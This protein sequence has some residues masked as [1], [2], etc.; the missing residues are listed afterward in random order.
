VSEFLL[1]RGYEVYPQ[2]LE[3]A[4]HYVSVVDYPKHGYNI[5][6]GYLRQVMRRLDVEIG[7]ETLEELAKLH[8]KCDTYSLFPDAA[9]AVKKAKRLG[10][11]TAIVTTIARF[12][13]QP[14]MASMQ[15]YFD[16]IVTGY[17]VGCEKSNPK[18]R[19]KALNSLGVQAKEAVMIGDEPLVD[20]RI[21]KKLGMHTIFLDRE[22][23]I[24]KK[25][26]EAD[27]EAST[28]TEAITL[29]GKLQTPARDLSLT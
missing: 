14:A 12:V 13:F 18:M 16:T 27:A 9:P 2:S 1:E 7:A 3:A 4:R 19:E 6:Q 20:I 15:Q 11:R 22:G 29:I 28:L 25:P 26:S 21:P 8:K 17:E 10:L 24:R 5:W 23:K